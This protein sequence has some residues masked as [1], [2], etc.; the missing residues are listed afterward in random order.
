MEQ[1]TSVNNQYIKYLYKLHEKKYRDQ[2]KKFLV[3]GEHLV[4]EAYKTNNLEAVIF[5]N[6]KY[7][8]DGVNSIFVSDNIIDKLAFTKTPQKI[9]GLCKYIEPKTIEGKRFLLLDSI[10]DPGNLGTLVRT[11]LGFNIDKIY[12]SENSVD[13]YNDKF[14]RSSQGAIFHVDIEVLN[15]KDL[16]IKLK[17]R[18]IKVYGTALENGIELDEIDVEDK[19]AIILGNEGSGISKDILDLTTK[20]IYIKTNPLLESLNVAIAGGIILHHFD[21]KKS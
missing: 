13:K 7:E 3:E 21:R 17:N 6:P 1:L 11:S 19:Y 8:L 2:E 15:L 4:M 9:I 20:N 14:I 16:V 18:G 12:I 10:Q 5:S